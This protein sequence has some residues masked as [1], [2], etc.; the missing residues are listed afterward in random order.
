M[1]LRKTYRTVRNV[2]FC[3]LASIK[4]RVGYRGSGGAVLTPFLHVLAVRGLVRAPPGVSRDSRRATGVAR[5][6]PRPSCASGPPALRAATARG[7]TQQQRTRMIAPARRPR[8]NRATRCSLYRTPGHA[9]RYSPDLHPP[10]TGTPRSTP[11]RQVRGKSRTRGASW[12]RGVQL[13][14]SC[15]AVAVAARPVLLPGGDAGRGAYAVHVRY[16]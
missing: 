7:T 15:W 13:I 8:V 2:T 4:L 3:A 12:A 11:R 6:L 16:R 9:H 1:Y 5:A 14:S 10:G